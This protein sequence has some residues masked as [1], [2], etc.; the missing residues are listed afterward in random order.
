MKVQLKNVRLCFAQNLF[1]ARAFANDPEATEKF[2]FEGLIEPG[3][4]NHLLMKKAIQDAAAKEWTDKADAT[5]KA[6]AAAG[7]V[8]CLRDGDSKERPEYHGR[9]IVSAKNQIR[10]TIIGR[11]RSP[12]TLQDGVIYSGCYGNAIVEVKAGSKPSKQVYAYL[13]G[14][15]FAEDG[16]RL[17]GS[18]ASADDFEEIPD[19]GVA[20]AA[21]SGK[22]AGSIFE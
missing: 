19:A 13:L 22:G 15:Q 8:W 18:V 5:L 4:E 11:N 20:K 14:F 21:E 6:V 12:L 10:P 1:I 3:S 17:G 2:Q 7:K 16:E 9:L